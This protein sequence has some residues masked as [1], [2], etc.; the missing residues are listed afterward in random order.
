MGFRMFW[1]ACLVSLIPAA[2]L[3]LSGL[4]VLFLDFTGLMARHRLLS[5]PA[6]WET[7]QA[8]YMGPTL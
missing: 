8:G 3:A 6:T 4:L 1:W 2:A 5:P 7:R